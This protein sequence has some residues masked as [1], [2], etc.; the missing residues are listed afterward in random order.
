MGDTQVWLNGGKRVIS[1]LRFGIGH[2]CQQAGFSSI[3]HANNANI[4][5]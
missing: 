3:G 2:R 1:N 4:R 5:E